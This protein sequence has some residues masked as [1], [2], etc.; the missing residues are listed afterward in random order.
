M[1]LESRNGATD[2]YSTDLSGQDYLR[3]ILEPFAATVVALKIICAVSFSYAFIGLSENRFGSYDAR[4]RFISDGAYW[5][6]LIHL[7]IV[8]LI[9]FLMFN[10]YIPIEI[11]FVI[12]IGVTSI[13]CLGTYRYLVRSSP[14]GI[15]LSGK[16]HPFKSYRLS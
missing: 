9:T 7:P 4:L 16:R 1:I 3:A 13:V 8:T 14:I 6:Y 2:L 5:M 10:L 11:K 12:A 15:L